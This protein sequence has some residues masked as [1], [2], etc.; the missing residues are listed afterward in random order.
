MVGHRP[1]VVKQIAPPLTFRGRHRLQ[2]GPDPFEQFLELAGPRLPLLDQ[3]Q[4]PAEIAAVVLQRRGVQL[5]QVQEQRPFH[6]RRHRPELV[7]P[8]DQVHSV[9]TAGQRRRPV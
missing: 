8:F 1:N 3:P 7:A 2:M 9:P 4:D 5:R 6:N